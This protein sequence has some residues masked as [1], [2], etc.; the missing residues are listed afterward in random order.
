[1][2]YPEIS[3]KMLLFKYKRKSGTKSEGDSFTGRVS[4]TALATTSLP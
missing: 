1:M 2:K 3:Q 4:G